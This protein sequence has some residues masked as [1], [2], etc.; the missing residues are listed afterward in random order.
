MP[1]EVEWKRV[2]SVDPGARDLV[3]CS[4]YRKEDT[5]ATVAEDQTSDN[6]NISAKEKKRR[7]MKKLQV[8]PGQETWRYSHAEYSRKLGASK[9]LRRRQFWIRRAKLETAL[10]ELPS[11]KTCNP[12]ELLHHVRE[13]Q[14]ILS[15]VLGL[16][17][18]RRV[19]ELRFKQFTKKQKVILSLTKAKLSSTLSNLMT[20]HSV[21]QTGDGRHLQEDC[22]R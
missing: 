22:A 12:V 21:P 15:Q 16:N 3:T 14:R 17:G 4:S 18:R 11:A 8:T 1:V 19:R 5:E 13:L 7:R 10:N 9:V 6:E 20:K 2:V